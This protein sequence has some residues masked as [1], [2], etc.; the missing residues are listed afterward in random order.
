MGVKDPD[1]FMAL[2]ELSDELI[3]RRQG[4]L[5][6]LFAVMVEAEGY[7]ATKIELLGADLETV[8]SVLL[9][10]IDR[11]QAEVDSRLK[12]QG[13]QFGGTITVAADGTVTMPEDDP[14]Q[15]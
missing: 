13:V 6:G 2:A 5:D 15:R 4:I 7:P 14:A 10:T 1:V 11:E 12:E 9:R 3:A 8:R